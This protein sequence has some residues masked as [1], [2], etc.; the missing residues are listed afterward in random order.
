M[1]R[2]LFALLASGSLIGLIA[3]CSD[4][5]TST[6][7]ATDNTDSG[8]TADAATTTT[9]NDS[10][11]NDSGKTNN[12]NTNAD[13]GKLSFTASALPAPPP[14]SKAIVLW[15]VSSGSPD[16]TY[17]FG[18]GSSSGTDVYVTFTTD[19][20]LEALN[21]GKL[22]VGIVGLVDASVDIPE[23]KLAKGAIK[24]FTYFAPDHAVIFRNTTESAVSTGWDMSFPQGFSCGVCERHDSGFDSFTK[25]DCSEIKLAPTTTKLDFCNW[26]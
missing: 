21:S 13:G 16:Y 7:A 8:V 15:P 22:G 25:V 10:G 17:A 14:G 23:G 9:P 20:P 18:A 26:T 6:P 12:G 4:D 19:P 1:H 24:S 11:S 2:F 3:A 5:A